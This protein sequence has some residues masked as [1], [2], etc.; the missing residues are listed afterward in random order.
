MVFLLLAAAPV[1]A[2]PPVLVR[3]TARELAAK[4]VNPLIYGN[5]IESGFGRQ[6]DG[7]RA[8]M[9]FNRSF[10]R[11]PPFKGKWLTYPAGTDLTRLSWWHSGY[12]ESEWRLQPG[13]PD[14]Q[15]S[16]SAY[17]GFH[18][19]KQAA[20]VANRSAKLPAVLAQGGLVLRR[21]TGYSLRGFA[22]AGRA[23][24]RPETGTLTIA[25]EKEGAQ[26]ERIAEAA[27]KLSGDAWTELKAEF[28]N[29]AYDG[30][31]ALAI[32][33]PPGAAV[34]LDDMSLMPADHLGG[35][36]RDAVE[37]LR[38]VRPAIIRFPGGCYASFG[39]WRDGIGPASSR[40]PQ[41]SEFWGGL[42][43]NDAGTDEFVN[44]CK[45]LKV[46]PFLVVNM[47]TGTPEEAAD[48]VAY[49]NA[50]ATHPMGRLRAAGGHATPYGVRYWELDN[51]TYRK[52]SAAEYAAESVRFSRAMKAVDPRIKLVACNYG[53]FSRA[54]EKLLEIAGAH[55]DLLSDRAKGERFL[56]N[57][58][59]TIREYNRRTGRHIRLC[60]TEWLAPWTEVDPDADQ[61]GSGLINAQ[62]RTLPAS[63]RQPLQEKQVT[64]RYAMNAAS[65]LLMF[66]R[67][68][69]DFEFANFNNLANTWGQNVIECPKE[70]AFL[71]AAGKV[72]ELYS[73]SPAAWPLALEGV[74]RDFTFQVQASL[75]ADR[76]L[77]VVDVLNY[78]AGAV[79]AQ[80]DLSALRL[81]LRAATFVELAADSPAAYNSVGQPGAV[82][83]RPGTAALA[84]AKLAVK[85][86]P[87]S[88][89][90]F[91]VK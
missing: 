45:L 84:G 75:S 25:L 3:V 11:I 16:I 72:M 87:F 52:W 55:I 90:Q 43:Y 41:E 21:G 10:E 23:A 18:H 91:V 8:E 35:W 60:N 39:N 2:A 83:R 65:T 15:F 24:N 73:A 85:I 42:E 29:P 68:G 36:R 19:G 37:L 70:A 34:F 58:L 82:R 50:P 53:G 7:L 63:E 89:T 12:E 74:G 67:L 28:A 40:R 6:V 59:A 57:K 56:E 22:R 86:A 32:S 88:V 79:D 61:G 33:V 4:P 77:V 81:P 64:W 51:E 17:M 31:A 13:N 49:C 30:R 46:E 9:L 47:M 1:G 62:E 26:R 80:V 20:Q 48:W 54:T 38:A 14:A 69:G 78:R 66:Q 76:K 71:S 27:V 44:L 5:F